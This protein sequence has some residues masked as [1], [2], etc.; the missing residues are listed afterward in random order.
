MKKISAFF[1]AV[2]FVFNCICITNAAT[3]VQIDNF[4]KESILSRLPC[5][6]EW[7]DMW[8]PSEGY[9]TEESD[10]ILYGICEI[11]ET[12]EKL[13]ILVYPHKN[14]EKGK[15]MIG[16]ISKEDR[17]NADKNEEWDVSYLGASGT[18]YAYYSYPGSMHYNYS[19][20][21]GSCTLDFIF[22]CPMESATKSH[23]DEFSDMMYSID[24]SE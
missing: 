8:V 6:I 14:S 19:F 21:T 15:E 10:R 9:T 22:E 12:G 20:D 18:A 4:D 24:F 5:T 2:L 3:M 13:T 7:N 11:K 16:V 23:I 17:E 1:L